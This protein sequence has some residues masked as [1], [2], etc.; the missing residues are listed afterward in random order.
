M[1]HIFLEN[2]NSKH[3][4]FL[5]FGVGTVDDINGYKQEGIAPMDLTIYK[6]SRW[7]ASRAYLWPVYKN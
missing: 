4:T 5:Q 2:F 6:G 3:S 1:C 7:S